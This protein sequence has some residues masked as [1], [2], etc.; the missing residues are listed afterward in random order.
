MKINIKTISENAGVS[1][2]TVSR[3]LRNY[4]G[5]RN[6]TRKKVLKIIKEL[7]YE[8]NE[9]ARSLRQNKTNTIGVVVGTILSPFFSAIAKSIEDVANKNNYNMILCDADENSEKEL[10]YL[11]VL[12]A[13]RVDGII[14]APTGKNKDYINW[15]IRSNTKLILI[16]RLI[17]GIECDAVVVNNE[18]GAYIAVKHLIDQGFK[19]IGILT[20]HQDITPEKERFNG[21]LKALNEA[22]IPKND[23]LIKIGKFKNPMLNKENVINLTKELIQNPDGIDAIFATSNDLALGALMAIKKA[24]LRIPEDIGIISFDDADWCLIL[25]SPLTS[26]RQPIY[27]LGSIAAEMLIKKIN[28]ENISLDEKNLTISLNTDLIIRNSTKKLLF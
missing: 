24:G 11:K 23:N 4:P 2:A 19:K 13:N 21:Y 26:I 25:E 28:G 16:D 22:G 12:T 27:N 20:T 10:K 9:V 18:R 3:V 14:L 8:V 15:L 1:T 5:V 7:N 17:E 6:I